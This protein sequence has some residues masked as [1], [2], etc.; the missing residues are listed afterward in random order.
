MP[1]SLLSFATDA[2]L[3]CRSSQKAGAFDGDGSRSR[4]IVHQPS[5]VKPMTT[6]ACQDAGC[7]SRP[8]RLCCIAQS[9]PLQAASRLPS[10][11]APQQGE[12]TIAKVSLPEFK[13][14]EFKLP[15][16]K[17][18]KVDVDALFALQKANLAAAYEAQVILVDA[19]QAIAKVQQGY[20]EEVVTTVEAALKT[21]EPKKPETVLA[22]AQ[23]AAEKALAVT[24]EGVQLGV[25]A[26]R[27]VADLVAKRVQANIEEFKALAA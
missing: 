9:K 24:K 16:L 3:G 15:E 14:P 6:L 26:Q 8:H 21:K 27:R 12:I 20:V 13:T 17:L 4:R 2:V 10:Y 18:P 19:A 25:A 23:A 5:Q 7:D 1:A 22:D 11:C